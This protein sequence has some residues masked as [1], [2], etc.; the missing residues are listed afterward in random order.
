M[1]AL[2]GLYRNEGNEF[3]SKEYTGDETADL[4]TYVGKWGAAWGKKSPAEQQILQD[5]FR[6]YHR[7]YR[8]K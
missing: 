5:A 8:G 2:K 3:N 6:Q 1:R 7:I 4:K